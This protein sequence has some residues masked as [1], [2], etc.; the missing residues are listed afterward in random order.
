MEFHNE[1]FVRIYTTVS[2]TAR[3]WGFFGRC[4]MDQL[5]KAA[6]RAGVIDLPEELAA[7]LPAAV[8]SL[9]HCEDTAWVRK[10]LPKIMEHGS[11]AHAERDGSH[12]L[13]IPRYHDGQYCN[14]GG[15]QSKRNYESK[16]RDTERAISLG[17]IEAPE[18][19]P[20]QAT[21]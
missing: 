12:Y 14:M 6:D 15:A 4:L 18:V 16:K 2:P 1:P 7:D 3:L 13:V 5:V 17:L 20:E 11:V 9:I 8:A 21:G 19:E 10:Y